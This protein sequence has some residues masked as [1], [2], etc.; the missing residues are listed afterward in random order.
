MSDT[1]TN[2]SDDPV[3]DDASPWSQLKVLD[4]TWM[5]AGPVITTFLSNLGAEVVK[6]ESRNRLDLMRMANKSYGW[7]DDDDIETSPIFNELA[8]GKRS[9][10]LDLKTEDGRKLARDLALR[11]D[12]VVE[13]MRPGK[14][15][16]LGLAPESLRQ[17]NPGLIMCSM[18]A[19]GRGPEQDMPGYAPIFWAEG[20]G[21]WNSGWPEGDP[22]Y[23]RGPVDLHAGAFAAFAVFAA[24]LE[25]DR[26]GAGCHIDCSGVESVAAAV[27]IEIL[28]AAYG[29]PDLGRQG[30][31]APPY[32]PNDVFPVIGDYRWVAI[33]V[34]D[35]NDWINLARVLNLPQHE[36]DRFA[37]VGARRHADQE[38][39]EL[40]SEST[41]KWEASE[42][43]ASLLQAGV[44]AAISRTL[45]D[46]LEDRTLR[47]RG[48]WKV[49]NHER[50]GEQTIAGLPWNTEG[51]SRQSLDTR[52]APVLGA[53]TDDVLREWL[54]LS[55]DEIEQLRS[56]GTFI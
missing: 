53:D 29:A 46:A 7:A 51:L 27:G 54:K 38:V 20:G 12:V 23:V 4:F 30:N 11:A 50:I 13:N 28:G 24:L 18:S 17:E 21:A 26:T 37:N 36:R 45:E 2:T 14:I 8:V 35:D 56:R 10:A 47:D 22:T 6:V 1:I 52:G 41:S 5:M 39:N 19:Y 42:L 16:S 40:V 48:F 31:A 25:R 9:I 3:N 34:R 33:S 44:P 49:L 32:F 55:D 43:V 15:E